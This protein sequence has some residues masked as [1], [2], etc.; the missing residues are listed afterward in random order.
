[1][2]EWPKF[3]R[4]APSLM[5]LTISVGIVCGVMLL[6]RWRIARSAGHGLDTAGVTLGDIVDNVVLRGVVR[7][8]SSGLITAPADAGDLQI[9]KLI[10]SGTVVS[11]G[12]IVVEFDRTMVLRTLSEKET[13]LRQV[14]AEIAQ[15]RAQATLDQGVIRA[16]YSKS[17]FDVE[18]ARLDVGT[19]GIV[20]AYNAAVAD[21]ALDDARLRLRAAEAQLDTNRMSQT[22]GIR[23]LMIRRDKV[24]AD[25]VR[26]ARQ[27]GALCVRANVS[28]VLMVQP[29]V[30]QSAAEALYR[31]GDSPPSGAIIAEIPDPST[32]YLAARVDEIDRGRLVPGLTGFATPDA[33]PGIA[34]TAR[35]AEIGAVARPDATTP[36]PH[37]YFFDLRVDLLQRDPSLQLGMGMTLHVKT[38][39]FSRT[40]IV[41]TQALTKRDGRWMVHVVGPNGVDPRTVRVA[42]IGRNVAA[43]MEGVREGERLVLQ[44]DGAR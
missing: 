5:W 36:W 19:R 8:Q 10:R 30:R 27:L 4:R 44:Q 28:G 41:P 3:L 29:S 9:I 20:S 16:E 38:E 15:A 13:E 43:I 6:T 12:D 32:L 37:T 14:Q 1:M 18:R 7:A 26:A 22:A 39:R 34:L 11:R 23:A 35:L 24:A 2:W 21:V 42:H 31:E 17:Y 40:L 33:L 25:V